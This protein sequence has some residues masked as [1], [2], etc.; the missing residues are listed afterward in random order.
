[1]KVPFD[2]KGADECICNQC[3]VQIRSVCSREKDKANKGVKVPK[4]QDT[5]RLYCSSGKASCNDLELKQMCICGSCN[6][7]H[8]HTL[9]KAKP[10]LHFCRDGAA[11]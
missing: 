1:M 11:K 2:S 5:A 9:A 10:T 3:P 6:V 7:W 8:R 4:P